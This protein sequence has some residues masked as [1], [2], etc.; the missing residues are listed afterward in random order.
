MERITSIILSLTALITAIC[1]LIVAVKK[2][3]KEFEE[4][5][6]KKIKKQCDIDY[7]IVKRMEEIKEFLNADR[8]QIYDFHNRRSL[9]E[10]KKC[11]ES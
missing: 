11:I 10:W 6:P 1:S 8:V 5:I 3:K 2:I 9:C 4:T 7:E